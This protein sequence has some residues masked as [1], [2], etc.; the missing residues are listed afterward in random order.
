MTIE[1][2]SINK[3]V[4]KGYYSAMDDVMNYINC[5]DET[6]INKLRSSLYIFCI[7]S[8]PKFDRK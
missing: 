2:N 8:R 4:R 6:D 7:E 3:Y 5:L 1:E